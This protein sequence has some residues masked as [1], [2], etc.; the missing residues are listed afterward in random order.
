MTVAEHVQKLIAYLGYDH[1]KLKDLFLTS[2]AKLAGQLYTS[3]REKVALIPPGLTTE[4]LVEYVVHFFREHQRL[5][6]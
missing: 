6:Q 5:F 1:D 2:E 4:S 3:L